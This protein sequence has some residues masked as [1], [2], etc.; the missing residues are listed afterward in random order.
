[1]KTKNHY[2][3][4]RGGISHEIWSDYPY[5]YLCAYF[6][7]AGICVIALTNYFSR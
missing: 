5:T 4:F 7:H 6:A 3:V 2:K 1:M